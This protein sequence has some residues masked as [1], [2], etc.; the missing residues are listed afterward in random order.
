[1][2]KFDDK[3]NGNTVDAD[4]YN[5]I[6]RAP[7]NAITDSGQAIVD[8]DNTQLSKAIANYSAIS[9]FYTDSGTTNSYVLNVIGSFKP[10][11]SY[12]QGLC[13]RFTP[14]NAATGASVVNIEA[15]GAKA[16]K[17]IGNDLTKLD[18]VAG[19][20]EPGQYYEIWYD[21]TDFI[22]GS[23]NNNTL[24]SVFRDRNLNIE[25][26]ATNPTYQIDISFDYLTLYDDYGN[27]V[28][29][30]S[31]TPFTVDLSITGAGGRAASEG[32]GSEQASTFYYL[33]V[34]SDGEG[35]INGLLSDQATWDLVAG[36]DKPSGSTF[37]RRVAAHRN[38][39]SSDLLLQS[40]EGN[41][42]YFVNYD[43]DTLPSPYVVA[44]GTHAVGNTAFSTAALA[45]PGE[46]LK[47]FFA[48][49]QANSSTG[50]ST[51]K[52]LTDTGASNIYNVS[53]VCDTTPNNGD[54]ALP[55][56]AKS[57]SHSFT[58]A[59]NSTVVDLFCVGYIFDL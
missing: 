24:N 6:V 50:V 18:L 41:E 58:V 3:A 20:L 55:N 25:S 14:G 37:V 9:T 23:L 21:G 11:T 10:P 27:S 16:I 1:M 39:S 5:D 53:R 42:V 36:G 26:N 13:A 8:V 34:Y 59:G 52:F 15:L 47:Y 30:S 12:T 54:F 49:R 32:G 7:R 48:L 28:V 4:D 57:S 46:S 56:P 31:T 38:D 29:E 19:D 22:L 40:Q 51:V 44:T 2:A 45:P 43:P 35:V 33:Y 17:R